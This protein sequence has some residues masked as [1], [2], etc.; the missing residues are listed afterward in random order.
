MPCLLVQSV[1][2]VTCQRLASG[3]GISGEIVVLE[4]VSRILEVSCVGPWNRCVIWR[5]RLQY[6][7]VL[8]GFVGMCVQRHE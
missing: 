2:A 1:S 6:Y 8:L 4:A 7:S 5:R 3:C